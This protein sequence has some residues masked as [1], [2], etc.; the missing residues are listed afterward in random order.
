MN[1]KRL[2]SLLCASS[3]LLPVLQANA[4]GFYIQEQSVSGLGSAFAGEAATPRDASTVYFNPAGMTHLDGAQVNVGTH[5]LI[6]SASLSNNG[7]IIDANPGGGIA[8]VALTGNDGGNPYSPTPVPNMHV[9]APFTVGGKEIW[10]GLSVSAPFG[11]ANEYDDDWFGRYDSTKTEL[12]TID[13][14]PSIAVDV[15]DWLSVGG[16]INVQHAEAELESVISATTS[17][18]SNLEGQDIS[19]GFNVGFMAEPTDSTTIGMHYRSAMRH[20]LDGRVSV[21]GSGGADF[22]TGGTVDLH[23]PDI[24]QFAFNQKVNEKL[25]VLGGASWYGWNNFQSITVVS[26]ANTVISS[27]IQNYQ[28]TWAF[29]IGA[30]YAYSDKL[31]LRAGY[32]FDETP[33]TDLYRTSRT[34]DGDRNWFSAGATYKATDKISIDF[35]ATYIDV[36]DGTIDVNRNIPTAIANVKAN[37]EGKVGILALGLNYKF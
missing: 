33:T 16:G 17:G 32:Q 4:A 8:N 6:P 27:V 10:L 2:F 18:L 1:T 31:T 13:V 35:A 25:S 3:L 24:A 15:T 12:T 37:S 22:S 29:S 20:E 30:E 11:L 5:L 21:R 26:D 23:L 7:S 14:A 36:G 34:P 9:A 19:Y 28:T